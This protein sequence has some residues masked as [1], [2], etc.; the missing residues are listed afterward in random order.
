VSNTDTSAPTPDVADGL[1][2]KLATVLAD[3]AAQIP[4]GLWFRI[5]LADLPAAGMDPKT[6]DI[7][8]K[9]PSADEA[10]QIAEALWTGSAHHFVQPGAEHGGGFD[11]WIWQ[12]VL[13]DFRVRVVGLEQIG[14]AA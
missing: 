11:H 2:F 6:A 9:A 1:L 4:S 12:G 10:R 3:V 7:E 5:S 8:I 13:G 14:G